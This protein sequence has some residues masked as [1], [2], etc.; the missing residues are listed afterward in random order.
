[1][2]QVTNKLDKALEE[3]LSKVDGEKLLDAV[4]KYFGMPA[5]KLTYSIVKEKLEKTIVK[6]TNE[7][8]KYRDYDDVDF[9][10]EEIGGSIG[11]KHSNIAQKISAI[12][13]D[14]FALN[15]MSFGMLFSFISWIAED[16][17]PSVGPW[18]S[19][20]ASLVGFTVIYIIRKIIGMYTAKH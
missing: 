1:M 11:H 5:N 7:L 2:E 16:Y 4:E 19:F 17:I 13:G 3:M 9:G 15:I 10:D 18:M 20:A 8:Q 6:Q 14:I 12:L